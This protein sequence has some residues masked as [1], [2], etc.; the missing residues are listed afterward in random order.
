VAEESSRTR[1]D[2]A[3]CS[4]SLAFLEDAKL[5]SQ[6]STNL[7]HSMNSWGRVRT[8]MTRPCCVSSQPCLLVSINYRCSSSCSLSRLRW[9]TTIWYVCAD[10]PMWYLLWGLTEELVISRITSHLMHDV[11]R[12]TM[13]L[14]RF[15]HVRYWRP[16]LKRQLPFVTPQSRSCWRVLVLHDLLHHTYHDALKGVH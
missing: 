11:S 16:G 9:A 3:W 6:N 14:W 4:R 13:L 15:N 5:I 7:V 2:T 12:R 10:I 1:L 8:F